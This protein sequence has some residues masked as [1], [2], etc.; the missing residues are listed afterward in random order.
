MKKRFSRNVSPII[1]YS[2]RWNLTTKQ[3]EWVDRL[4]KLELLRPDDIRGFVKD[5]TGTKVSRGELY[6]FRKQLREYTPLIARG[7]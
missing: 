7:C 5:W 1:K 2:Y 3:M 6:R 4:M